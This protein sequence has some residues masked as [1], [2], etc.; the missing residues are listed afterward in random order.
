MGWPW[1]IETIPSGWHLC[2]GTMGTP[3]YRNHYLVC[4]GDS[5][6]PGQVVGSDSQTHTFTGDGHQHVLLVGAKLSS[7]A[8]RHYQSDVQPAVG[9]TD[10]GDNRPLSKAINWI[11]KL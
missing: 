3:D 10:P 8:Y 7:G 6:E 9:T 1:S 11:M 4:A 2:D 5:Y